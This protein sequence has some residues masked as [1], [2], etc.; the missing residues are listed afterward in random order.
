MSA[1]VPVP[2]SMQGMD[3]CVLDLGARAQLRQRLGLPGRDLPT[4][5]SQ[6]KPDS[7]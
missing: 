5:I 7:Q 4:N 1:C 3:R 2:A 6:A